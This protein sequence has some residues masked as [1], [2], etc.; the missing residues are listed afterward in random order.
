MRGLLDQSKGHAAAVTIAASFGVVQ[1]GRFFLATEAASVGILICGAVAGIFGL[2]LFA[3]LSRNFGRWF[4]A[5]DPKQRDLRTAIG[6]GLLPWTLLFAALMPLLSSGE[7]P[8]AIAGLYPVFFVF[9]I[10][11]YTILLLSLSAAL[12]ISVLKTFLCLA[13]TVLVSL[14]PLTLVAQLLANALGQSS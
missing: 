4:G 2:Y 3:W 9:L 8:E 5:V 13:V 7:E 11:G 1:S 12:R 6:L 10:Y 14:F